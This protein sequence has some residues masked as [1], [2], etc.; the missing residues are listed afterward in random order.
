MFEMG[1]AGANS[2]LPAQLPESRPDH[3]L[4]AYAGIHKRDSEPGKSGVVTATMSRRSKTA[5]YKTFWPTGRAASHNTISAGG[6][7]FLSHWA[8]RSDSTHLRLG[9]RVI[10]SSA[11]VSMV[12]AWPAFKPRSFNT[13]GGNAA[14]ATVAIR[15]KLQLARLS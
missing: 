15:L 5:T 11:V 1:E 8:I 14:P 3:R 9:D 10:L 7:A 4:L 6:G 2:R 12:M 13:A